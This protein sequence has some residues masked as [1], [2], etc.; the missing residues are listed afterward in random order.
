VPWRSDS[1]PIAVKEDKMKIILGSEERAFIKKLCQPQSFIPT[2]PERVMLERFR[3]DGLV[4]D[5][6]D[7]S[8]EVTDFGADC[9]IASGR[10]G[11]R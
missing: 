7:G 11:T 2:F 8:I 1:F 6:E 10:G 4:R 5:H 3:R 9:Y